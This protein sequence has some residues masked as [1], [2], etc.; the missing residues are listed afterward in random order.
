[1]SKKQFLWLALLA[2]L[3][4]GG[5]YA[6]PQTQTSIA[7][8]MRDNSFA[9][10]SWR[11]PAGATITLQLTNQDA[12]T[13]DWTIVFRQ[14]TRP[15]NTVDPANVY[16]QYRIPAGKSETV[17]FTAPAAAGNY[18]VVSSDAYAQGMV[19]NLIVVRSD[20]PQ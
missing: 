1:M 5:C 20:S 4:V 11:V 17:Q 16:W 14:T 15:S 19:G 2:I 18:Q 12:T 9:P 13:H 8:T 7:V 3:L 6:Q 10:G